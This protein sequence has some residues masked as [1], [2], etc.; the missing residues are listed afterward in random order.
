MVEAKLTMDQQLKIM[1]EGQPITEEEL[2][3]WRDGLF[4][5]S[6]DNKD[7]TRDSVGQPTE[8]LV[9]TNNERFIVSRV[10]I[11][12]TIGLIRHCATI[13]GEPHSFKVAPTLMAA[14]TSCKALWAL[15]LSLEWAMQNLV[16]FSDP[17]LQHLQEDIDDVK[18]KLDKLQRFSDIV[19]TK[20]VDIKNKAGN[21]DLPDFFQPEKPKT[22]VI[23]KPVRHINFGDRKPR[24][25]K[26]SKFNLSSLLGKKKTDE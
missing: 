9:G 13:K 7:F 2:E 10:E 14:F 3:H 8:E 19:R 25:T 15:T 24:E 21:P 23:R 11:N 5:C 22:I 26:A 1:S 18:D 6:F 16:R 4:E 17:K 12:K 20:L